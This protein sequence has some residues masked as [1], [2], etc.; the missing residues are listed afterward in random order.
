M[1]CE[2][3]VKRELLPGLEKELTLLGEGEILEV[4]SNSSLKRS[5][6]LRM[7]KEWVMESRGGVGRLAILF[8]F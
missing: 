2:P 4:P 5:L 3:R 6:W 1:W 7:K 8:S